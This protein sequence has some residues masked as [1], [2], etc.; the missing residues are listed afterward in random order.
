MR[1]NRV[2]S[3][4]ELVDLLAFDLFTGVVEEVG[5]AA[6]THSNCAMRSAA[7]QREAAAT[8]RVQLE[9]VEDGLEALTFLQHA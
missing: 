8:G 7:V 4:G 3:A 5:H 2:R 9:L 6:N 1:Q